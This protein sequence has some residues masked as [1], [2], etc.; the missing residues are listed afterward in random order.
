MQ[1]FNKIKIRL[2]KL[3]TALL[4][5]TLPTSS[6]AANTS[7]PPNATPK[8]A[9]SCL[10]IIKACDADLVAKDEQ[11]K[12]RDNTLAQYDVLTKKQADDIASK[13]RQLGAW[14]NQK[15]V[16]VLIGAGATAYLIKK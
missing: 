2:H 12:D 10:S 4:L 6:F 15:W 16:W 11:I 3:T 5:L 1:Q 7:T 9:P 8:Q 13:D 14:Y